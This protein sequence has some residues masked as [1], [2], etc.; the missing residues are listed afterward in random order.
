MY[1]H[2]DQ[3]PLHLVRHGFAHALAHRRAQRHAH[4]RVVVHGPSRRRTV[5]TY[6]WVA[7]GLVVVALAVMAVVS[8]L[9]I[10][11]A[12]DDL[13]A[14]RGI[15]SNDVA[16]QALLRSPGGRVQL[17]N[18]IASVQK[19]AA[20]AT[21]SLTGSVSL[22]LLG[23]LPFVDRQRSGVI[24]L[25]TDVESA[26]TDASGIVTVLNNLI[27]ASHGTTVSLPAL[28]A[29]GT[30]VDQGRRNLEALNRTPS[31]LLGPLASAR[32][33]F[34]KEDVKLVR[35]LSLS[36]RT[37]DFALPFLGSGGPQNYLIAG[38]NNAEMRDGGAVLSLD[39]L[40][41]A[42]GTFTI[43]HDASY[44]DYSLNAPAPVA[45]PAGTQQVFGVNQPTLNWP[46]T[47][48]TPDWA[49]SGRI[50]EGMWRQ[51]TGQTVNGVIGMDVLG[52]AR[53]LQLTG[54]VSVPGESVPISASNISYQL[55]DKAYQG[56]TVGDPQG[57]R[58]DMI[59]AVIKAAV[60]RMKVEHIDLDQLA[61][62]LA[63]DVDGR[64]LMVWTASPSAESGLVALDAAGTID[65]V[66]PDRT[67]HVAL[68]NS[69]ADKLDYLVAV[70]V[71]L[72]IEV[73]RSGNALINATT[74]VANF[75]AAGQPASYQYGPDDINAFTPGQYAG[76]LLFW[77]PKGS[78]MPGAV[79][80]SGL[81]VVQSH[82][83]LLP[84]QQRAITFSAVIPH[85]V[86]GG[87]LRL[88]LVP[89]ARLQPDHL[90]VTLSAPAWNVT[91]HRR[92]ST[93]W[94]DTLNLN[95][96]MG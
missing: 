61:N 27:D 46:A 5:T 12:E 57:E 14:A 84:G 85:A 72:H 92:L 42:N 55:L 77:G 66:E 2:S 4:K 50:M 73:D 24:Q 88:R 81:E 51:A 15:I 8:F 67:I 65:S 78:I 69:A 58:R 94:G 74:N 9:S 56:L 59:A 68:E 91:G 32:R 48:E 83:S 54:P 10:H 86:V 44:A 34:D 28:S 6:A 53:I 31:G 45:L 13:N 1:R 82:F 17:T 29:L 30:S 26:A 23:H 41:A 35:V 62:A 39:T 22:S 16:D 37:I 19:D 20:E 64:H 47:D 49:T 93:S 36:A 90:V 43:N 89:Q 52:V 80:E 96:N 71:N 38:L 33:A 60:N 7:G 76:H 95:W 18:D 87:H 3:R 21:S 79:D 63:D 25:S 70:S 40:T 11:R 75:A